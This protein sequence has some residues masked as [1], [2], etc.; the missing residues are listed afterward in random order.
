VQFTGRRV[1]ALEG[2]AHTTFSV[3]DGLEP[4][5]TDTFSVAA[6]NPT[7][8]RGAAVTNPVTIPGK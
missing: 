7:G 8:E 6:V 2:T 5:Q 4:G 3:V 1:L